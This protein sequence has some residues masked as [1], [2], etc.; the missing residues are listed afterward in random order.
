M[1]L[2][3]QCPLWMKSPAGGFWVV[4][5]CAVRP[6]SRKSAS[7]LQN[8]HRHLHLTYLCTVPDRS[9]L[10]SHLQTQSRGKRSLSLS[11]QTGQITEDFYRNSKEA[12]VWEVCGKVWNVHK[13]AD[14]DA[15]KSHTQTPTQF[16]HQHKQ[17]DCTVPRTYVLRKYHA[18]AYSVCHGW[19][20]I[21]VLQLAE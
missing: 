20:M 2:H 1:C 16:V 3:N 7:S 17:A 13:N 9:R 15:Q 11:E 21:G 8:R 18:H 12:L 10:V 6:E 19:F 5:V 14:S 4:N